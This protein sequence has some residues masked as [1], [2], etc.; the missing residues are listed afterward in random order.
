MN[1]IS[2][3]PYFRPVL[4]A[5]SLGI[6]L[7]MSACPPLWASEHSSKYRSVDGIKGVGMFKF[8]QS[9]KEIPAGLLQPTTPKA[10][11]V[12]LHLSP[13]GKN[14]VVTNVKGMTWGGI[15]VSGMVLTFHEDILI[16]F[17]I[18]LKAKRS[19]FYIADRAF[20][21]KYGPSNP[22]T[23][24]VETWS[25][26]QV[27]VTLILVGAAVNDASILNAD[28]RGKVEMFAEGLWD[29]FETA[30]KAKLKEILD[31]QYQA[32]GKQVKAD[33]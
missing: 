31:Q 8:G 24:P 14:Y 18:A 22:R 17:Q 6:L 2:P 4:T 28:A 3:F 33:L 10:T 20:K 32:T 23:F 13:Y 26:N 21:E 30:R 15:P 5:L 9:I 27:N 29:K 25:G 19:A 7:Q 12:L 16:D 1:T 11:G